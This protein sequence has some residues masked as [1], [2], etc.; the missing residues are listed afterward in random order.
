MK[1]YGL[2]LSYDYVE[3]VCDDGTGPTE[4][5]CVSGLVLAESPEKAKAEF[6]RLVRASKHAG[7]LPCDENPFAKIHCERMLQR[8][9]WDVTNVEGELP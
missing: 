8:E 4:S 7:I 1:L 2:Y 9:G 6:V 3:V 5:S